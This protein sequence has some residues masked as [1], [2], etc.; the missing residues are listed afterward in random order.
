MYGGDKERRVVMKGFAAGVIVI[1]SLTLHPVTA[2]HSVKIADSLYGHGRYAHV[3][4]FELPDAPDYP[5][6]PDQDGLGGDPFIPSVVTGTTP[7]TRVGTG[8]PF[9]SWPAAGPTPTMNWPSPARR[10]P[11]PRFGW[12]A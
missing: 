10:L 11:G 1:S 8:T 4:G 2:A 12:E 6:P 3:A 7:T 9:A 5:H